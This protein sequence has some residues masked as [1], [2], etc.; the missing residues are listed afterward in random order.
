[1]RLW[2]TKLFGLEGV[3]LKGLQVFKPKGRKQDHERFKALGLVWLDCR[4]FC[5]DTLGPGQATLR[6]QKPLFLPPMQPRF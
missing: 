5:F 4:V 1:M 6:V 3:R 2:L